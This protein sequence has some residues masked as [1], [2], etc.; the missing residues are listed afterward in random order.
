MKAITINYKKTNIISRIVSL[1]ET[2]LLIVI[3]IISIGISLRAPTFLTKGNLVNILVNIS[4]LSIV[5]IGQMI[6]ILTGG[7]DL[8]MESTI[9]FVAMT[10]GFFIRDHPE[11]PPALT[12]LMGLLIGLIGGLINGL[13]VSYGR[14][15]PII[16][17]ISTL[18]IY[19]GAILILSAGKWVNAYELPESF[20][21][22]AKDY[23]FGIPN[24]IWIALAIMIIGYFFLSHTKSGRAIY[25]VG[26]NQTGAEMAGIRT[27]R[28]LMTVY[29][30]SGSLAGITGTLWVSRQAAA[31]NNSAVGYVMQTVAA[32]VVGGVSIF[33]GSGSVPGLVLGALLLGI[34]SQSMLLINISPYWQTAVYGALILIAVIVDAIFLRRLQHALA[35]RRNR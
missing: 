9:G 6:V 22:M 7:I 4:L 1:R 29:L 17:T 23:T 24:L 20:I 12:I 21:A 30:I 11:F 16:A 35:Q 18:G 15:P 31:Y 26:G 13:L 3:L 19:R 25:A 32:C 33:G 14:V 27:R 28:I 10:I 8:S 2:S 5:A 34:V